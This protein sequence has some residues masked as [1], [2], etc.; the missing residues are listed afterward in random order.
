MAFGDGLRQAIQGKSKEIS[1]VLSEKYRERVGAE[2]LGR[3]EK[4][5]AREAEIAQRAQQLDAR[6]KQ[7]RERETQLRRHFHIRKA[8]VLVPVLLAIAAAI[9]VAA[10][11]WK[12]AATPA[13]GAVSAPAQVR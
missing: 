13:S 7:L 6:E 4:L 8:Y 1:D 11:H 5:K 12:N 2:L 9:A 10:M 3:E